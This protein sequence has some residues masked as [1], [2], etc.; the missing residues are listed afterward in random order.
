MHLI[1]RF[2]AEL[3][4]RFS[5]ELLPTEESEFGCQHN[6]DYCPTHQH[7]CKTV[8]SSVPSS[9]SSGTLSCWFLCTFEGSVYKRMS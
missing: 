3:I 8:V 1:M 9:S 5:A 4:M 6:L 7:Q 2:S